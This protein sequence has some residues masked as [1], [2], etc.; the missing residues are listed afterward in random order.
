MKAA[1]YSKLVELERELAH[2]TGLRLS[3]PGAIR[4]LE[5]IPTGGKTKRVIV[6]LL[7]L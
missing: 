7:S 6:E 2:E 1:D 5:A 4:T 3:R